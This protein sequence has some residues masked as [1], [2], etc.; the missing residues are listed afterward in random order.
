MKYLLDTNILVLA[1]ADDPSL[2]DVARD[3]IAN[4][5]HEKYVSTASI[6]EIVIKHAKNPRAMPL[7]GDQAVHHCE[8]CGVPLISITKEHALTVASLK[9]TDSHSDP[10]DRL[11]IA[12]S[13]YENLMF[14]TCDEHLTGYHE[15]TVLSVKKKHIA[16]PTNH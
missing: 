10:F 6:W 16:E 12:Q 1:L 15:P 8:T 9:T 3:I 14:I 4:P 13:K 2:P 7:S 11:L 5:E